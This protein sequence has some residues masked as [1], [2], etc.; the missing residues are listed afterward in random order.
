MRYWTLI[1]IC[2][3]Y[4]CSSV[5]DCSN[6]EKFIKRINQNKPYWIEG[7]HCSETLETTNQYNLQLTFFNRITG[8]TIKDDVFISLMTK[9]DTSQIDVKNGI[10]Q[11][12]LPA[13]IYTL[14]F[15][16]LNHLPY[17]IKDLAVQNNLT[18]AINVFLGSS[19]QAKK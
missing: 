4:S 17:S 8:D 19:L 16:S 3:F 13:N 7:T 10:S 12:K 5:N 14:T 11:I 9:T 1:L 18:Q 6:S 2:S 15:I